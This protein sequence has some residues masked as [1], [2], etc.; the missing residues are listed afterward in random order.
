[1][2]KFEINSNPLEVV[3]K[4]NQNCNGS[5]VTCKSLK[6]NKDFTYKISKKI[7]KN[8]TFLFVHVEKNYL[9]FNYL[10]FYWDGK[11]L[12]KGNVEIDT[13]AATAIAWIFK[14]IEK[15]DIENLNKNVKFYHTGNCVKCGKKLT[16]AISIEIGLGPYCRTH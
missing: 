4:A 5:I 9:N 11:I 10:G 7:L 8:K 3:F 2:D 14:Q 1:M 13:P 16:D 12:R 15:N 6:T